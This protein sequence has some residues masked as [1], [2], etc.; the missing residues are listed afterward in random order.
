MKTL[1]KAS[2]QYEKERQ[3]E[4][5]LAESFVK[6]VISGYF[7]PIHPKYTGNNPPKTKK[8]IADGCLC[9]LGYIINLKKKEAGLE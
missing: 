7:C 4:D 5:M 9:R 3:I 2:I 6:A 8:T 1:D